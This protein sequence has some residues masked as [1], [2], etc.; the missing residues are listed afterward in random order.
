[1]F[2]T[3][4]S[5]KLPEL[6][7]QEDCL[8]SCFFGAL[9]Y[10]PPQSALFP[11]LKSANNDYLKLTLGEYLNDRGLK[12]DQTIGVQYIFWP[13]SLTFGEP[14]IV[15]AWI[16]TDNYSPKNPWVLRVI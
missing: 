14:D 3:E 5:G 6:K 8:T 7:Y 9:K 16:S 1:M 2:E 4:F 15:L 12:L 13:K 10:L 11:I